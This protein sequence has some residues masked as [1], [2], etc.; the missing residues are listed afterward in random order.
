MDQN[1][2]IHLS[3]LEQV[4]VIREKYNKINEITGENFNI[5][6]IL[7]L[8]TNE[9]RTHSAFIC[10]LLNPKGT[11]GYK[12][13]FLRLFLEQ[14]RRKFKDRSSF[15]QRFADFD[16]IRSISSVEDHIGI[17]DND[18]TEGGRIDLL[19]KD[20]KN[21]AIIIENKIYAVDQPKQLVRYNNAYKRA[22]IFYLTLDGSSPTLGSSGELINGEHF[23][24]ISYKSDII[25]WLE[26]CRKESVAHSLIRETITQYINLIKYLTG[27]TMNSEQKNEI[28][29]KIVVNDES[30]ISFLEIQQ[31]GI[32]NEVK[33]NLMEK[34]HLQV[35]SVAEENG[36]IPIWDP[37]FNIGNDSDCK[38][39]LQDESK[40]GYYLGFGFLGSFNRLVYGICS[41]TLPYSDE[42]RKIVFD[43]K[44]S[45]LVDLKKND[46]TN[47]LWIGNFELPFANW[48]NNDPWIA[49]KN[50]SLK[51]NLNDKIKDLLQIVRSLK[52]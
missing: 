47:W 49:I 19:I 12:D 7:N 24:S 27:Q 33:K 11:H 48:N 17:I 28:V 44:G 45:G 34:F 3:L 51:Q 46:F 9:V 14:Q 13:V 38:L 23:V 1:C 39:L 18:G 32:F 30:L 26:N 20:N 22:P 37:N 31:S 36:L 15:L 42:H 41:D 40:F 50:G 16:T 25:E 4:S 8:T 21:K 43:K 2:Q 35:N 5:F 29:N 10:E 52:S 6:R